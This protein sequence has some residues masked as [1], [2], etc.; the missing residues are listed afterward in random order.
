MLTIS[1]K[2]VRVYDSRPEG[3]EMLD[4]EVSGMI[5]GIFM[6]ATLKAAVHLGQDY[7]EKS[8]YNQERRLRAGRSIVRYLAEFE[9]ESQ[10][11]NLRDVYDRMEF[12]SMDEIDFATWQINQAVESEGTRVLWFRALSQKDPRTSYFDTE[13]ERTNRMFR[14]FQGLQELNGMDGGPLSSSGI[15]SQDTQCWVCSTRV[16]ERWRNTESNLRNL[17]IGPSSCRC[18]VTSISRKVK[19]TSKSMFRTLRNLRL[20]YTDFQRDI[21]LSSDQKKSGM[22]RTRFSSKVRGTPQQKRWCLP[23]ERP[24]IQDFEQ[25]VHWIEDSWKARMVDNYRITATGTYRM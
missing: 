16:K 10:K 7:E 13:V 14:G 8:A 6:S 1:R 3:D 4:V 17:K 23:S 22:E 11:W 2:S 9:P 15:S 21:G 18:T 19:K 24:D 12:K 20:T 5:L 25:Q